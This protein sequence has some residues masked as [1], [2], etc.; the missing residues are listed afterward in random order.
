MTLYPHICKQIED[1]GVQAEGV[2][3]ILEAI[4]QEDLSLRMRA[5][6]S[7]I[8]EVMRDIKQGKTT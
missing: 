6:S 1:L 5:A 7:M 3:E 2:A 8:L 4:K